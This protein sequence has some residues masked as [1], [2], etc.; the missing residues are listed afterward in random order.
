MEIFSETKYHN[1]EKT[2]RGDHLGFF[3][4]HSVRQYQKNEGGTLR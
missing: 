2:E 1:A 4:I 3:K